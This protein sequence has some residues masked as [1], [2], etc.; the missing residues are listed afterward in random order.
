[1]KECEKIRMRIFPQLFAAFSEVEDP[2]NQRYISYEMRS[3]LGTIYFKNLVGLVTMRSMTDYFEDEKVTKNVYRYLGME[4]KEYL[5]HHQTIN[6]LLSE[7]NPDE[8]EKILQAIVTQMIRRKSFNDARFYR[9]WV[10]IVDATET[11]SGN[12]KLNSHCLERCRNR[13]TANEKINYYSAV[14]E[15]KI[16]FGENFVVSIGSE[17]IENN[18]EDYKRQE[19][20][21]A[22]AIKQDCETK[23]FKRLAQK[24][25]E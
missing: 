17:F 19:G 7:V 5:P 15:A 8:I 13:G 22:E 18:G 3:M 10:I 14:L 23:A 16:Y 25:K 24:N 2:R 20:M 1:M 12:R 4:E 11:Y 6:D 21:G 9:K